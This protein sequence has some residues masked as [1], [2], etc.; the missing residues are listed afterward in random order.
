MFRISCDESNYWTESIRIEST[1]INPTIANTYTFNTISQTT[2]DSF[3]I[4]VI[5]REALGNCYDSFGIS[6][7][8]TVDITVLKNVFAIFMFVFIF[9]TE[10]V[11]YSLCIWKYFPVSNLTRPLYIVK[12]KI[13]IRWLNNIFL[14]LHIYIICGL[15]SNEG[16]EPLVTF[17]QKLSKH[18]G[19]KALEATLNFRRPFP[20]CHVSLC[21]DESLCT[22]FHTETS[23]TSR[24]IV[25]QINCFPIWNVVHQIFYN[26]IAITCLTTLYKVN[27]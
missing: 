11:I 5:A 16:S 21:Q 6:N 26:A 10:S 22:T 18:T 23:F 2:I 4:L 25:L 13:K 20:C 9:Y 1:F 27:D 14:D 17:H 15:R 12:I 19:C 24:F 3:N 8:K 7:P